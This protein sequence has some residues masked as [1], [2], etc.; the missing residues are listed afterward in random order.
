[1][2]NFMLKLS[3]KTLFLLAIIGLNFTSA[4]QA[5]NVE[6]TYEVLC[7]HDVKDNVDGNLERETTLI[8]TKHLASHLT[9]LHDHGYNPIRVD[10][11]LNAQKGIKPL[12]EKPVLLTFDD[13]YVSFYT[14]VYPLL[15]LFNYPAVAA[16]EG[17]WLDA[18][19]NSAVSY[20]D[21]QVPRENFLTPKQIKEMAESGLVEF[22]S[23]SYDLHKGVLLNPYGNTAPAAITHQY[24]AESKSYETD[25]A[26]QTRISADLKRNSDF[27]QSLTGKAPR[28]MVWPYG[29]YNQTTLNIAKQLGMPITFSLDRN[30]ED[31]NN[32]S[33]LTKINRSLVDANP[34]EQGLA[35]MLKNNAYDTA[36]RIVHIDLDTLYDKD[37]AQMWRNLDALIERIKS[38]APTAVYLQAFADPDGDGAADALYFPN[39]HLPVRADI[40]SR[41]AR[42]LRTRSGVNVYAWMPVFAFDLKD[43]SLQKRISV[44]NIKNTPKAGEYRRLSPFSL[45]A[46]ALIADIYTDLATHAMFD[47]LIF[48]D[49]ASL[50][51]EEDNSTYACKV[52]MEEWGL[53]CSAERIKSDVEQKKRWTTLKS[54]WITDFTVELANIVKQHQPDLK[55]ARN[56]YANAMLK[57]ESEQWLAQNYTDFL[58]HYD[59]TVVMAMPKMEQVDNTNEWLSALTRKAKQTPNGLKKTIFEVQAFDW[60]TRKS[61]NDETLVSQFK[62]LL[63]SD[64]LHIGYYPDNFIR[65]QPNLEQ[66][67]PY[68]SARSFPYLPR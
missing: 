12:P 53:P 58:S 54:R 7:Y 45:E 59:Y 18:K 9:W 48:H 32:V 1:M 44:V 37:E 34:G 61:I 64:A 68:M 28:I 60:A 16:L 29:K 3:I 41:V 35:S 57:P 26:Y 66:I 56:L 11:I 2:S 50:S 38:L 21:E 8:S 40:F 52:Y 33:E 43:K 62:H 6:N 14:H 46:R 25:Q 15:K 51:D 27:I 5:K 30:S 17:S 23:H 65:N 20:G 31:P 13:G 36:Q 24:L 67:R 49:D 55:T 22:A 10:D 47:G 39:R 19:P 4:A 63:D 42:Q